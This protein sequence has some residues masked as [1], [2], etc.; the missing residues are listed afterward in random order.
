[1]RKLAIFLF[2]LAFS[3]QAWAFNTQDL[4]A[5]IAMPLAVNAVANVTG[6]PQSQLADFVTTLN[7][8]N[9]QPTQFVQVI[10]YVPVALDQPDFVPYVQTQYSQGVTGDALVNAIVDRLR[11]QYN[12]TPTLAFS[13]EPTT[14]VVSQDYIPQT[15]YSTDPLAMIALPLAVAAV[16][17]ITGVSQNELANF[18]ATLNNANVPPTQIVE[19]LRYVPVALT[20][21]NAPQFVQYVQ[22]QTTHGVTGPALVPVVVQQLQTFYPAQT[23][24]VVS[25][26]VKFKRLRPAPQMIVVDQNFVPAVVVS[27]MKEHPHGGPPGQ[28]KKQLGLQTGAEVV[29]GEKRQRNIVVAPQ[30][31]PAAVIVPRKEK[32][33][34]NKGH[35][36]PMISAAPA[37]AAAPVVIAPGGDK[38]KQKED[39][40]DHGKGGGKGK[41]HGKD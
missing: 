5:T 41:G 20:T 25:E 22:Q 9:V 38:G 39:H 23:Q 33:H 13:G 3:T 26:P 34:G 16:S 4:L 17:N 29:H 35:E 14:Y 2:A 7:Q 11:T 19:V 12:V 18:V 21:D 1:M 32:E 24:I 27:R 6:V 8:A 15:V 37:A 10:R 28:I 36:A 40:G 30:T 31:P